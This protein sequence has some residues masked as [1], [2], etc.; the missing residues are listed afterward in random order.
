MFKI[1][2]FFLVLVLVLF[3]SRTSLASDYSVR[4]GPSLMEGAPDAA[5]KY[6]AIRKETKEFAGIYSAFE[7]G[8]WV[9]TET[10]YGR[11]SSFVGKAQIG[12]NPGPQT[13]VYGKVFVGVAALSTTDCLLGGHG[14]FAEDF[15]IGVRD[16]YTNVE[17][18]YS[19]FS[20]A[21]LSKPN[22]GRDFVLFSAGVRF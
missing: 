10:R 4:G 3:A 11:E 13:G 17:L 14:Q 2:V 1:S 12:V 20:S 6:F 7:G 21:G 15:G 16:F 9:D 5:A 22:K 19:H 8:G 18:T